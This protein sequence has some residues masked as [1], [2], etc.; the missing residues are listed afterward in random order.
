[1]MK[2]IYANGLEKA[3]HVAYNPEHYL[4]NKEKYAAKS[5]A[6]REANPEKAKQN[7]A[8]Y[9]LNNKS[10]ELAYSTRY[11]RHKKTGVSQEQYLAKLNEQGSVCAI[12]KQVDTK[13]LAADH[14]HTTGLFRGLLCNNCNRGLG[15]FQDDP[16]LLQKAMEYLNVLIN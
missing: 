2:L 4:A 15:H 16:Q 14:C 5:K 11:N 3:G 7:R 13:A 6:W 1:M 9:Y 12:C 10:K 8:N